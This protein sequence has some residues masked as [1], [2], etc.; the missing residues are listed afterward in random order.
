MIEWYLTDK[1]LNRRMDEVII[2]CQQDHRKNGSG[3]PELLKLDSRMRNLRKEE[4]RRGIAKLSNKSALFDIGDQELESDWHV[5]SNATGISSDYH[6]VL[7][8]EIRDSILAEIERRKTVTRLWFSWIYNE[9]DEMAYNDSQIFMTRVQAE[10]RRRE[11]GGNWGVDCME[12][13]GNLSALAHVTVT[14]AEDDSSD[15]R[16]Y[17][18][19][20][21]HGNN[22]GRG[23]SC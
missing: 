5:Y 20:A 15:G 10:D 8:A 4:A 6:N 12:L 16:R 11:L 13:A 3:S 22:A 9:D 14:V 23:Q 19:N 17:P 2:A 18:D 1:E 7:F 21:T